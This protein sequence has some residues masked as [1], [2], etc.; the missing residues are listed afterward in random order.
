MSNCCFGQQVKPNFELANQNT[1]AKLIELYNSKSVNPY[2]I[3]NNSFIFIS[4][5]NEDQLL[6]HQL[7]CENLDKKSYEMEYQKLNSATYKFTYNK[8]EYLYNS[9]SGN[10]TENN[11]QG[12]NNQEY[13]KKV[14]SVFVKSNNL[15]IKNNVTSEVRQLSK[16]AE[17]YYSFRA[18]I[19]Y[20]YTNE[21]MHN[22]TLEKQ[23]NIQWSPNNEYFLAFRS[24]ARKIQDNWITNSVAESRPTLTTYKQRNPGDEFPKDEI[25]LY[26][27]ENLMNFEINDIN[28]ME[29]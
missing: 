14:V 28:I 17:P 15:F 16:D 19:D 6:L 25:W 9:Y 7:N 20:N 21:L 27:I 13:I 10:I 2:W 22:D 5:K 29:Y 4:G 26:F 1:P 3:D 24:D 23:A 11:T 8:T 18:N 12:K